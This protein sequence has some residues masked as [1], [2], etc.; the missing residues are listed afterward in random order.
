MTGV[1]LILDCNDLDRTATRY[2]E[3]RAEREGRSTAA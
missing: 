1:V 3:R 2:E